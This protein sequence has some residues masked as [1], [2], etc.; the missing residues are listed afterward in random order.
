LFQT[1]Y[2]AREYKRDKFTNT[3]PI[4]IDLFDRTENKKNIFFWFVSH[5]K[6][7]SFTN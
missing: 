6:V 1:T 7:F 3:K 5:E 4:T 2:L